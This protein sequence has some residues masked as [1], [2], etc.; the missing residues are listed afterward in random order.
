MKKLSFIFFYGLLCT[1]TMSAQ[2]WNCGY[3]NE[4]D[5]TATL[6]DSVMIISGTGKM[7]DYYWTDE[8]LPPWEDVKKQIL[9]VIIE[10][11]VTSVGD[12]AF[13]DC[14]SL[15]DLSIGNTVETIGNDAFA[16][17][18][19][20]FVDIP[21]GVKSIGEKS[22]SW[23]AV[24]Y[25]VIS[26][27]VTTIDIA[28]FGGSS[29]LKEISVSWLNPAEVMCEQAF[30]DVDKSSILLHTPVGTKAAYQA[31]NEWKDFDI[32]DDGLIIGGNKLYLLSD[33]TISAGTLSPQFNPGRQT[34][35][36]TVP[37]SIENITLTATPANENVTVTGDGQKQ[38]NTGENIVE[39]TATSPEGTAVYTV[40]IT[41]TT[42]DYILEAVSSAEITTGLTTTTYFDPV[43]NSNKTVPVIDKY[44]M[45]YALTTGNFSGNLTLLFDFENGRYTYEKDFSV[46]AYS[47]YEFTLS[48]WVGYESYSYDIEFR[49]Y[50][51]V[52]GRPSYTSIVYRRHS[53]NVTVSENNELVSTESLNIVGS[54][55]STI[56]ASNLRWIGEVPTHTVTFDAHDLKI[57][58]NP[59]TDAVNITGAA[60]E[61]LRA[62]SLQVINIAG[63]VVHTQI[64]SSSNETIRLGHLPAGLYFFR[65]EKEGKMKMA[66]VIKIQ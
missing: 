56:S 30:T 63:A 7:A 66:K 62:T 1:A 22:F 45:D 17:C 20:S 46:E 16:L 10:N 51:D 64:I 47:R 14:P 48:W 57:Y 4:T 44:E 43:T 2:T 54:R 9:T 33:I 31:I 28:A 60:V 49:T 40:I 6:S 26:E 39:I 41:R 35:R 50:Y 23:G 18:N 24:T 52:Y 36:V 61:T 65:V 27:S 15:S 42:Y 8:M 5:V 3:P 59:F 12:W 21:Y 19:I 34:Y 53:C 32:V 11:G 37:Q 13:C 58:P 29:Q 25:L 55:I 38:L